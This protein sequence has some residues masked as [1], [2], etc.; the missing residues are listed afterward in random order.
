MEP[1]KLTELVG[2]VVP[3]DSLSYPWFEYDALYDTVL[4]SNPNIMFFVESTSYPLLEIDIKAR[5]CLSYITGD[6]VLPSEDVMRKEH[7]K[8]RLESLGKNELRY[9]MDENYKEACRELPED[10]WWHDV[11]SDDYRQLEKE[12]SQFDFVYLG[13][14]M[15][16]SGDFSFSFL[17]DHF[18]LSDRAMEMLNMSYLNGYSRY[19]L[20][21][22]PEEE[23]EWRTFR[24]RS[25]EGYRSL[26]T[27]TQPAPLSKR[28]IDLDEDDAL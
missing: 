13:R 25:V 5:L 18:T 7:L 9:Y 1:N 12:W 19:E 2:D 23:K 6:A 28:W 22:A 11:L 20:K 24:D 26:C 15:E 14:L 27:G 3:S 16:T 10:T 17:K 4:I 21:V 8:R